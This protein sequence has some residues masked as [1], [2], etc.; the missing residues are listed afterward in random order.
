[1]NKKKKIYHIAKAVQM[2]AAQ[3][4]SYP[5]LQKQLKFNSLAMHLFYLNFFGWANVSP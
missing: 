1:M 4:E 3:N 2:L 5:L